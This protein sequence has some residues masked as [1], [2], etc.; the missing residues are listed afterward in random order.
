MEILFTWIYKEKL[1]KEQGFNFSPE[2]EFKP[3]FSET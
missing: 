3:R 1:I 2:Y